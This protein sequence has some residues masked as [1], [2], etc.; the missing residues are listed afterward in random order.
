MI[1]LRK[2]Q[3]QV[4]VLAKSLFCF[5]VCLALCSAHLFA[6]DATE[7][8]SQRKTI[9]IL[10]STGGGGHIA[11]CN[12]LQSLVGD[13]YDLKMAYPINQLR[14]WGV[15]S[16]EQV[17]NSM[18]RNGWIRSMNFIVRNLAPSIFRSY[19]GKL[20][21]IINSYIQGYKPDLVVSVI[22][23]VNLPASEAARKSR[24]AFLIITTDNDLRNWAFEIEKVKHPHFKVTIG[25]DLPT[26]RDVLLEKNIPENAIETIGLPLRT[27]FMVQ[28]DRKKI[29]EEL[30]LPSNKKMIL[31]MMGA[32][33]GDT[34][35]AYAKKVGDLDLNAHIVVIAGRNNKLKKQLERLELHSS[36]TM[37]VFGFTER[38]ADIM[39][40]SNVIITKPGPGTINEAIA[41]KLPIL[42]DNTDIT[43][44][45]ERAN[46]DFVLK[47]GV[48]QKIKK[49]R[50]VEDL[51]VTYLNDEQTILNIE[52]CFVDI[53][54]NQFHLRIRGI[55]QELISVKPN[56]PQVADAIEPSDDEE[57]EF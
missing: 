28:K 22:P 41:M 52:K 39:A 16:C 33:G 18:L 42:I 7:I 34:A 25:A 9:L 55:I 40:V 1:M 4:C 35:Y 37:T 12:T 44:F 19:L 36:N 38:V 13:E 2:E 14:I 27:E 50:Q 23:F 54:P 11:A 29:L 10:S 32:A 31:I 56:W 51:L 5:C 53:P 48:G 26:T 8:P 17:Y 43:L 6:E 24:I 3:L 49:L 47:Y 21:R 57:F 46:V 45:W 30:Q 15:P 20:E